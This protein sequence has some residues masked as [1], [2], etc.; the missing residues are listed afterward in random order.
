MNGEVAHR[1]GGRVDAALAKPVAKRL[2]AAL[3][4]ARI[5]MAP[6]VALRPRHGRV[7]RRDSHA[8]VGAQVGRREGLTA[9]A[10][11]GVVG[12]RL[13]DGSGERVAV[14]GGDGPRDGL[15]SGLAH[16]VGRGD[17]A[18]ALLGLSGLLG[19]GR[20]RATSADDIRG[21]GSA[22]PL[23]RDRSGGSGSR[24]RR[25]RGRGR[26]RRGNLL[27][28]LL[29]SLR[30]LH[31]DEA[32]EVEANLNLELGLAVVRVGRRDGADVERADLSHR[33]GRKKRGGG[34]L[35]LEGERLVAEEGHH[36]G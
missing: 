23:G 22:A 35:G 27:L 10:R 32:V 8:A 9:H 16:L 6:P 1:V 18:E 26:G 7:R 4:A 21:G 24:A 33:V 11:R 15:G 12:L 14:G 13:L 2:D 17:L 34:V 3:R 25:G 20:L 28:D 30:G 31:G 36:L 29:D 5:R 19:R